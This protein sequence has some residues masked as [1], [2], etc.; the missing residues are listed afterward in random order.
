MDMRAE[1]QKGMTAVP[2]GA[3]GLSFWLVTV[4]ITIVEEGWSSVNTHEFYVLASSERD[5]MGRVGRF[6]A[7]IREGE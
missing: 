6:T 1:E 4:T 7:K 2:I 3:A 5:A